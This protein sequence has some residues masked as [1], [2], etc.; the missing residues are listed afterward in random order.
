MEKHYKKIGK[1]RKYPTHS[2][3]LT[4]TLLEVDIIVGLLNRI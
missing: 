1:H 4:I 2:T 3:A